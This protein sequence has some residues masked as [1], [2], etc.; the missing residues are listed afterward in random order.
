[1]RDAGAEVFR[2]HITYHYDTQCAL[3]FSSEELKMI[4]ALEC[5]VAIDCIPADAAPAS[6]DT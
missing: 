3:G 6:H 2:L 5:D 4:A 1:M